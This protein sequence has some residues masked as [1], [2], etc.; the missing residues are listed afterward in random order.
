MNKA[1]PLHGASRLAIAAVTGVTDLVEAMH[2]EIARLPLTAPRPRTTGVTGLVYRSVRGVTKMVGG[3]MELALGALAPLLGQA[4]PD[5]ANAALAAL[6][7]VLGDY[8]EASAN[9]LATPMSLHPLV[10]GAEGP[11]LV[12]LHGLCMNEA[13]WRRDGADFP[14]ALA[15]LGY[16]PLGLRYNSGRAI[17]RNG[18]DLAALLDG[19]PGPLTL[20][21]HSMGGLVARSAIAQAGRRRWARRL[22]A[23][24]TLGT[25]HLGAPLERGGQQVQQLLAVSAY[26]RPLAALAAR[27]SAGIRDLRHGS[28]LEADAGAASRLALPD[29][30]ACYA[31]A[32]TTAKK[33]SGPPARWLGDGLVPVASA[34]GQ[35]REAARRLAF[36]DTALFTGLGHLALQTD[37]AVLAQL[38]DWLAPRPP[39]A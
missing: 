6:N 7:G 3:G 5:R 37:P 29:G 4:G 36:T 24:V 27:R 9:P 17:W 8:L 18:A 30:V 16:R 34:L 1:H 14:A 26:S 35:H 11:P 15:R 13:Q 21:G 10:D 23:L 12:L 19:V 20:L 28:L 33:P 22:Q 32:A 38:Q 25:P 39:A 31:V 2:A